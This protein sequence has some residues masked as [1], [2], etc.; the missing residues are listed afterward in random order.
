[1]VALLVGSQAA[2]ERAG[3][4]PMARIVSSAVVGVEPRIMGIGP[5]PAIQKALE[6]AGLTLEQM[7][8]IEI[9]E[10]FAAQ[11]LACTRALKLRDDD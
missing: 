2:G 3:L 1:A 6:R 8:V 4:K 11:A 5:V 9:N 10:A 7:D